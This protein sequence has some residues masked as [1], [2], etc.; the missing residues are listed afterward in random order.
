M[1]PATDFQSCWDYVAG[2]FEKQITLWFGD[3]ATFDLGDFG[4]DNSWLI[5]IAIGERLETVGH[6]EFECLP[7]R[8]N[9]NPLND[10]RA[11]T[12]KQLLA[13]LSTQVIA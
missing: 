1:P 2:E 9:A 7:N 6:A 11:P 3:S 5:G 10:P 13:Q 8:A 4:T 12:V